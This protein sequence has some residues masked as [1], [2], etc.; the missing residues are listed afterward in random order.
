MSDQM[1][2]DP[3]AEYATWVVNSARDHLLETM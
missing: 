3:V 1:P 2:D